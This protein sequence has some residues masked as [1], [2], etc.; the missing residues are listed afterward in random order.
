MAKH[1]DRLAASLEELNRLRITEPEQVV[2]DIQ[3]QH[4]DV[5]KSE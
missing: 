2:K 5:V 3:S 4:E 1:R